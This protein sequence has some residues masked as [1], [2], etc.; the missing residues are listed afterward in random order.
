MRIC[1]ADSCSGAEVSR[2]DIRDADH[3]RIGAGGAIDIESVQIQSDLRSR[4]HDRTRI[5]WR[6]QITG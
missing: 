2:I 6:G 3:A 1:R 5:D 4:D